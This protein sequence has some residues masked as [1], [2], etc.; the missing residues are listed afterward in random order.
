MS[1]SKHE[2]KGLIQNSD[3][4]QFSQDV[5]RPLVGSGGDAPCCSATTRLPNQGGTDTSPRADLTHPGKALTTYTAFYT[6]TITIREA[7]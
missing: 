6:G 4:F 7:S 2:Q 1:P 5:P 3:A